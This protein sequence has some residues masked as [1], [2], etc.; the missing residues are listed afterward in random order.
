MVRAIST[1]WHRHLEDF[2]GLALRVCCAFK[3]KQILS[4]RRMI[5]IL[6]V[7]FDNRDHDSRGY[8]SGNIINMTVRVI[9]FHSIVKPNNFL[10]PEP[11]TKAF[12]NLNSAQG[13]IPIRI[14]E[15]LFR[16]QKCSFAIRV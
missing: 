2:Q 1:G 5:C 14:Q 12:L 9:S 6:F 15:A 10:N 7:R 3:S 13:G 11:V 4:Q 16:G 8:K